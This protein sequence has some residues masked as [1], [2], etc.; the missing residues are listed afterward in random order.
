MIAGS[1]ANSQ[2]PP[3]VYPEG[4]EWVLKNSLRKE[5]K[6]APHADKIDRKSMIYVNRI[7]LAGAGSMVE[8]INHATAQVKA[9]TTTEADFIT[10]ISDD[11]DSKEIQIAANLLKILHSG[12]VENEECAISLK[13]TGPLKQSVSRALNF[14]L[15][16]IT[17]RREMKTYVSY[18]FVSEFLDFFSG[19]NYENA[20]F[21]FYLLKK[22]PA[23]E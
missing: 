20:K 12:A 21:G 22:S 17:Y 9:G 11:E 2:A 10:G 16:E 1:V 15:V 5:S 23:E 18:F 3:K 14:F 19:N 4:V 6:Y 8:K 7:S 13:S